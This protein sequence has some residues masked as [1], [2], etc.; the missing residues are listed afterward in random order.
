MK[1]GTMTDRTDEEPKEFNFS[2]IRRTDEEHKELQR[3]FNLYDSL[4]EEEKRHIVSQ[5]DNDNG[6]KS[7]LDRLLE[8]ERKPERDRQKKIYITIGVIAL[9]VGGFF[10]GE[11]HWYNK[12]AREGY[13]S[14]EGNLANAIENY[15]DGLRKKVLADFKDA[16]DEAAYLLYEIRHG[17]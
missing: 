13:R 17:D 16:E 15:P 10:A 1:G 4:S 3:L 11:Q 8:K 6:L 14:C 2:M 9:L 7:G 5:W 12:G